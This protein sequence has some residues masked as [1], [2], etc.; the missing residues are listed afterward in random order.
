M[1]AIDIDIGQSRYEKWP[2][3]VTCAAKRVDDL[4]LYQHAVAPG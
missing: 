3:D 1:Q 4:G 2:L